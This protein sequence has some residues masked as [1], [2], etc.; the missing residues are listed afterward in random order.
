MVKGFASHATLRRDAARIARGDP[1][2]DLQ[3]D[4][5]PVDL[6]RLWPRQKPDPYAG[7]SCG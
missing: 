3:S 6:P 4:W 5:T 2:L 7:Q 1:C